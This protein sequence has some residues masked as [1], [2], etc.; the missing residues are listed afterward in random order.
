[1]KWSSYF[2]SSSQSRNFA[3]ALK[4]VRKLWN[5]Y[6]V[7]LQGQA[8]LNDEA[9]VSASDLRN[10]DVLKGI[11]TVDRVGTDGIQTEKLDKST[12]EEASLNL[13]KYKAFILFQEEALKCMT[14]EHREKTVKDLMDEMSDSINI[15]C[16]ELAIVIDYSCKYIRNSKNSNNVVIKENTTVLKTVR[17]MIFL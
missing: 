14:M 11:G 16:L 9:K 8:N 6:E 13:V 15:I 17:M 10:D 12:T 5:D 2:S 7:Y 4:K 3:S 1:M